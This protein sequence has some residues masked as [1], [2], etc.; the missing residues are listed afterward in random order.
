MHLA[1]A[2]ARHDRVS[3]QPHRRARGLRRRQL[4]HPRLGRRHAHGRASGCPTRGTSSCA[5]RTSC[6]WSSPREVHQ[7]LLD[8]LD[9]P[10]RTLGRVTRAVLAPGAASRP[11]SASPPAARPGGRRPAPASAPRPR[12][13]SPARVTARPTTTEPPGA[14]AAARGRHR[15]DR[16]EGPVG[17]DVPPRRHR[18]RRRAGHHPGARD[19]RPAGPP[20]RPG[21]RGAARRARPACWGSPP[22]RRTPRTGWSTPTS[23]PRATTAS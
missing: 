10:D 23:A 14:G 5:G 21:R 4:R 7:E 1:R 20:G 13:P 12:R 16:A 19:R 17:R 8:L 3:L 15:R 2:A 6:R 18:P 22:P 11:S 9:E